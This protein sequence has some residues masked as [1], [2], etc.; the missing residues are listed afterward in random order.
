LL[1][2]FFF[3]L[4]FVSCSFFVQRGEGWGVCGGS[5][6]YSRGGCSFSALSSFFFP[7]SSSSCL[8]IVVRLERERV[9]QPPCEFLCSFAPLVDA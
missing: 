5:L 7:L 8:F 2:F 4:L 6:P 1:A 9:E 3:F